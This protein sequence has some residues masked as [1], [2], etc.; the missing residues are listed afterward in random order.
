[1]PDEQNHLWTD[2]TVPDEVRAR[3]EA[4]LAKVLPIHTSRVTHQR[5]APPLTEVI[6]IMLDASA[7]IQALGGAA[8]YLLYQLNKFVTEVNKR[9]AQHVADRF[10]DRDKAR[11][12]LQDDQ[13]EPLRL[14]ASTI[15]EAKRATPNK[16]E[17][18]I[19]LPIPGEYIGTMLRVEW[20]DEVDL[21][22]AIAEFVER[23]ETIERIIKEHE[24]GGF[25]GGAYLKLQPDGGFILKWQDE[26]YTMYETRIE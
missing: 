13:A 17:V 16:T 14:V 20:E 15:D 25:F 9:T 1:M 3:L 4:Q 6:Q 23:A 7:W 19:G 26:D 24:E 21:A 8:A 18:I 5:S 12:L 11:E 22:L 10:W 2:A